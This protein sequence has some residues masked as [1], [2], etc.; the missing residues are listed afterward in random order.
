MSQFAWF[1]SP[2]RQAQPSRRRSQMHAPVRLCLE[3]LEERIVPTGTFQWT[4]ATNGL[5][6]VA[7]NWRP[8][9]GAVGTVPGVG[10]T[11][12]IA[13]IAAS[14]SAITLTSNITLAGLTIGGNFTGSLTVGAAK[15]PNTLTISL[16]VAATNQTQGFHMSADALNLLGGIRIGP[17]RN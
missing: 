15:A 12:D 11:D 17:Q 8:S 14:T 4:G 2:A 10:S 16:G 1:R 9:P 5:W 13:I 7:T 3:T 6:S